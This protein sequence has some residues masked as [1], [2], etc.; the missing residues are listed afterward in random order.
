MSRKKR[1]TTNKKTDI[2][3]RK[4]M[5]F[6]PIILLVFALMIFYTV[7]PEFRS[8][9]DEKILRKYTDQDKATEIQINAQNSPKILTYDKNIGV[10]ERGEYKTYN[11]LGE[12]TNIND[13]INISMANPISK[14]NDKYLAM[15]EKK[16]KKILLMNDNKLIWDRELD[17]NINNINVNSNG[18]VVAMGSN[19]MYKSIV[20]VISNVGDE[21][22]IIY[23]SKNI[24]VDA[25]VSSDNKLLAIAEVNYSKPIVE[26]MIKYISTEKAVKDPSNSILKTYTKNELIIDIK[27]KNKEMLLAQFSR[28]ISRYTKEEEKEIYKIP[29]TTQFIDISANKNIVVLEQVKD[30]MFIGEYQLTILTDQGRSKAI[31][32]I[33]KFVPKELKVANTNIA[34]NLGQEVVILSIDGWE[35]KKYNS[36]KDIR[37]VIL[38]DKVCAI[39]YK[40]SFNIVEI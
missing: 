28:S 20:A 4:S 2:S 27:F 14:S 10:L 8:F 31:Y 25:E 5:K 32:K 9:I 22:F 37:E 7:N 36:N 21:L 26:S 40:N 39:L 1:K 24:V 6:I 33:G 15:A 16:G 11:R 34:V 29:D 23:I 17:F 19:S 35:K 12:Q 18:Y 30:G 3:T 38:S 13:I